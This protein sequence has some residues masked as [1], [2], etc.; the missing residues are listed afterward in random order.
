[1]SIINTRKRSIAKAYK[2]FSV[3]I[4]ILV[5]LASVI[6]LLTVLGYYH[7]FSGLKFPEAVLI[8]ST[9]AALISG[10]AMISFLPE[11]Y[12]VR[13]ARPSFRS[14]VKPAYGFVTLFAVGLGAT[15]GSPL[16]IILPVNITQY[17]IVSVISLLIAGSLS[18]AISLIYRDMFRYTLK[19]K[20]EVIGGPSF[21]KIATGE[22]SARYFIVRFSMWLANTAL[23]AFSAVFFFTFTF[24]SFPQYLS[25]IGLSTT[26]I[27]WIEISIVVLFSIWF[28]INA[29]FE[30]KFLKSIG[31]AQIVMITIVV[32]ILV[33]ESLTLGFRGNW[34]FTGIFDI[35][36]GNIYTDIF[37]NTGFLFIL[38]FGFQEIQALTRE[39]VDRSKIPLFH[40]KNSDP[41]AEK[42]KYFPLSMSLT[43]VV[44]GA[45]MIFNALAIYSVHPSLSA[46]ENSS[47]PA[48]Y[49]AS[50]YLGPVFIPLTLVAF[51]LA[52]ITTFIPAIIAASKHL[53]SLS[54]DGFFPRS[55]RQTSW[56]FTI[57]VIAI[58]AITGPDFLVNITDF[59][60]LIALGMICLAP[61]WLR[62]I[63]RSLKKRTL[64]YSVIAGIFSFIVDIT[65]FPEDPI[66]VLV[67]IIAVVLSFF[68]YDLISI[69][70][71]GLQLFVV[72]FDLVALS[73][74]IK[75]A[76]G[77]VLTVPKFI[78]LFGG[79]NINVSEVLF[80]ILII[81]P[82][83]VSINMFL[84]IFFIRRTNYSP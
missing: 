2:A 39:S 26:Y 5:L 43:V 41:Y 51:L 70:T 16:F 59:M 12:R 30:R 34:N 15:I 66:V 10:I 72:M 81:S 83:L 82:V 13:F 57:L 28:V 21:V 23:A 54:E 29:F 49:I 67:G 68:V 65:L 84:D 79:L 50:K 33:A 53:R 42:S 61:F 31:Y 1:M 11:S 63:T 35:R 24:E 74:L 36:P 6:L 55:V 58:L 71:I 73:F 75:F 7:S 48:I 69:G 44:A 37:E 4:G 25:E 45:I 78:S 27:F 47:I 60:V 62:K 9:L 64:L 3:V 52:T 14:T 76:S 56:L 22:K 40:G 77:F 80:I 19:T 20:D 8:F 18:Y 32:L 38:F 17:A 46:L